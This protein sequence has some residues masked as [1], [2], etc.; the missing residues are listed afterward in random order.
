MGY[1]VDYQPVKKVRGAER[2][3]SRV[4]ALTGLCLIVFL[5]LVNSVWPQGMELLRE[6][7]IPGDTAVTVA[8]LEDLASELGAG[9][10]LSGA[11]E[12]FCRRI[13]VEAGFAG[14]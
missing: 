13:L 14:S 10:A 8:A 1:R 6:L 2:R 5:I 11:L 9:E 4:L 3:R 7:L 12:N